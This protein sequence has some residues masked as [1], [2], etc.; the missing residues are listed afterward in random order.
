MEVLRIGYDPDF[1]PITFADGRGD[2]DG[3]AIRRLAAACA[4]AGIDCR[5]VPVALAEQ[6]RRLAD[7]S[8]DALAAI[9]ATPARRRQLDLSRVYLTTGAAWFAPAPFDPSAASP[10][11]RIATPVDGPLAAVVSARWPHLHVVAVAGYAQALSAVAEGRA[12]AAALNID[13]G[14]A[15]CAARFPGAFQVPD[16]PFLTIGLA[17]AWGAS[18]DAATRRRLSQFLGKAREGAAGRAT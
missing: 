3:T 9:G 12:A 7:G 5:F 4:A 8:V 10:A 6:A 1:A 14:T 13:V 16:R 17:L 11:A 15:M 18:A 2:A